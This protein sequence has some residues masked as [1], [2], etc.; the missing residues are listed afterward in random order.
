MA[1]RFWQRYGQSPLWREI[2]EKAWFFTRAGAAMYLVREYLLEFTV[3]S[4]VLLKGRVLCTGQ[5]Q[6]AQ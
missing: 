3:V 1:S 5:R 6:Q 4:R 2:R